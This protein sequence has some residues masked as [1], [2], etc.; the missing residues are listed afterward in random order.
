MDTTQRVITF[1][2]RLDWGIAQSALDGVS[3]HLAVPL[4]AT[5]SEPLSSLAASSHGC[6]MNVDS[7]FSAG[8]FRLYSEV[9]TGA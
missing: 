5:L 7:Q 3:A 8:F 6:R 1:T 9:R 2:R 4:G